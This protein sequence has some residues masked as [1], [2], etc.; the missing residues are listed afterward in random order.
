MNK[1]GFHYFPDTEHYRKQDLD[2][3]LPRLRELK[4]GWLTMEAP[5]GRAIP[6]FFLKELLKSEIQPLLHFRLRP[7][8]LPARESMK[9][10]FDTYARWGVEYVVLFDRPNMRDTWGSFSWARSDLVERF[11]DLYLPL[12][13]SAIRSGLTPVFPPLE[14]GGDYWDTMFLR[15][16]LAGLQ[17]RGSTVLLDD[18]VLSAYAGTYGHPLDWGIGGPERWP[19]V[20]PYFTPE[21]SEDHRGFRIVDWYLTLSEAILETRLPIFML[22]L[23]GHRP[24][25]GEGQA[26]EVEMARLLLKKAGDGIEPLPTEVQGGMFWLLSTEDDSEQVHRRWFAADGTPTALVEDYQE[27]F[28]PPAKKTVE[29]YRFDHYL[30]LPT[31]EWG[32]A[33]WH[34]EV[35]RGF[36]KKH[37]PTVGFSLIEAA[38]AKRVTVIGGEEHFT[39]DD[40]RQL[41][42]NGTVVRRVLGDGTKVAAQLAAI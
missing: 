21:H 32:V 18:I 4:A 39:E 16:G 14:P 35:I 42:G 12:A 9:L 8:Q 3:W 1:I 6:E 10:F 36:V 27:L 38:H 30:L 24:D 22:G 31:Y 40:I 34:L 26:Q 20:H 13:E 29:G 25:P 5:A 23:N 17:R 37:R 7:D 28:T 11:L 19:E 33:D 41:R 2:R 15:A